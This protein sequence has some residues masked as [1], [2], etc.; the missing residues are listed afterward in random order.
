M[1]ANGLVQDTGS[2]TG[3]HFCASDGNGNGVA[4]VS[5]SDGAPT[6]RYE[7]GPFGEAIRVTG[8]AAALNPFRFSTKRT[9][10]TTDLVLYEYRGY[11][12][13][14]GRWLTRDPIGEQGGVSLYG[15]VGSDAVNH[16]DAV[17]KLKFEGCEGREEQLKKAF[18]N[19][20]EK[21]KNPRFGCCLSGLPGKIIRGRL[22]WRCDH[23]DDQ[24]HGITIKCEKKDSGFCKGACA[25]SLPG[26]DKI[27]VCPEQWRNPNCGDVGCTLM[28]ELTPMAG[29][30]GEK[31]PERVE[32][33]LGCR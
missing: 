14:T 20:C 9:C 23:H 13:G 6:T 10:N 17:G 11:Q 2:N 28:H 29:Y 31:W 3:P 16:F 33:C 18:E 32:K 21:V 30:M 7:Y 22:R 8:P 4:L 1:K 24:L 26:G 19:Y 25:W 5:A 12:L 27:H 15:F